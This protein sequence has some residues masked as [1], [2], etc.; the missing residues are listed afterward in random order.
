[1]TEIELKKEK[2]RQNLIFNHVG[3]LKNA[4]LFRN[5][6]GLAYRGTVVNHTPKLL[7][8]KNPR[9][10]HFGLCQGS[11]DLIG[12]V[13]KTVTPDMVG[14]EIAV[15]LAVEVKTGKYQAT[16]E[17]ENFVSVVKEFGGIAGVCRSV[18]EVDKLINE[19]K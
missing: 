5:N 17:Q 2:E 19:G 16:P 6:V 14:S 18:D 1:M 8:L 12:W 3:S 9:P 11:S 7:T 10:I 13:K 4:R 15:F